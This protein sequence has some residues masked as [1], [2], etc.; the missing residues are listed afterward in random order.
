[1]KN[2]V[3]K[4]DKTL[5]ELTLLGDDSAYGELVVR[6][7]RA[8]MGVS[9]RETGNTFLAE[10][11]SQ[12][13][14]VSAWMNLAS[15]RD[16]SKFGP[17][18]SSIAKNSAR[19]LMTRYRSAIPS[20]SLETF[21]EFSEDDREAEIA[22]EDYTDL[23]ESIE[24]LSEKLRETVR[25]HYFE[26][27]SVSEISRLLGVS[28]GTVKW[29]LSEGRKQ[30]RK[31]YGIVEKT[32]N[33][34]ESLVCRVM[35]QV[36]ELKKWRFKNDKTGFEDEYRS[37]LQ[38]VETLDDS[39]EKSSLLADTLLMGRWWLESEKNDET[40]ERIKKSAEDGHNDDVMQ[41]VACR[42][43]DKYRGDEKIEFMKNT[44]IPYY[45]DNNY[46]KTLAYVTF[47]LGCEYYYKHEY[48]EAIEW[49]EKVTHIVPG[50]EVY[51]A[52]A[53]AA[54]KVSRRLIESGGEKEHDFICAIGERYKRIG[55]TL[56]FAD[57]PGFG[58]GNGCIF[59]NMS[60]CDFIMLDEDMKVGDVRTSSDCKVTLR[61][62]E[63]NAACDTPA[64]RFENCSVFVCEGERNGLTYCKTFL[65]PGVGIVYQTVTIAGVTSEW[66]LSDYRIRG[67]KGLLPFEAG[68]SWSYSHK[69]NDIRISDREN[70]FEVT[71]CE[72]G[73]VTLYNS[74][75]DIVNG[76]VDTWEGK[77]VEMRDTYYDVNG[78]DEKL[79][80][81]SDVMKRCEELACT[82][83]QK[84]QTAIANTVMRRIFSTDAASNP[85]TNVLGKWDFF[86]RDVIE[87][88]AGRTIMWHNRI[89]DFEWKDIPI[90][91]VEGYK[92]IYSFFMSILQNAAGCLWSDEWVD[93]YTFAEKKGRWD[94]VTKNF[95]VTGGE[96]VTTPAGVFEDCRHISF[97]FVGGWDYCKGKCEY[98]FAPG[99]GIVRF[100]HPLWDGSKAEWLLT[101]YRGKGDGYFPTDDGFFR[102]YE[103]QNLGGGWHAHAEFTF[104]EDEN[105]TVM[106]KDALGSRDR[107]NCEEDEQ[108]K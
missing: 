94:D 23:H 62:E 77:S 70:F 12:D 85:D 8:V 104:D 31:G 39:K 84:T 14:F 21:G 45:R 72:N 2:H 78:D 40:F 17:W 76:Y 81:V 32:Y 19:T 71:G 7:Q 43:Y 89:F 28:E 13:A 6:H 55:N 15:L 103:P 69:G 64:G 25:L 4:T 48:A 11:A 79:R 52:N 51:H 54:I 102:R 105:G 26:D 9:V 41:A 37:V 75:Y 82:K 35:R 30:L 10:D 99:V 108:D 100:T 106:F 18:V 3:D 88:K 67:G 38:S 5:V 22:A 60:R 33:E 90:K 80:D 61:Y 91:G 46:P 42:E 97:E 50:T 66:V 87:K 1:M 16:G 65:C 58:G 47:W 68:N 24:A 44:Q 63:D 20:I 53:L 49:F 92:V 74:S 29:R 34:K 98:W 27:K 83:R 93:G 95:A 59:W 107:K 101:E 96:S 36:E 57:M 73:C 56:Y 86:E